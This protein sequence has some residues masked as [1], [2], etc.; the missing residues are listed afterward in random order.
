[1]TCKNYPISL[2]AAALATCF[3][4]TSALAISAEQ[5]LAAFRSA[6]ANKNNIIERG[7]FNTFINLLADAG[8]P[9]AKRVRTFGVYGIAFRRTD[10]NGDGQLTPNELRRSQRENKN[11]GADR[12]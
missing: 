4:A 12:D 1:M 3:M 2:A 8:L 7:E 9:L 10:A 6:D 11:L 5:E